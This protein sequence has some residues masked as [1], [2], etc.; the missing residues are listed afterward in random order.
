[1]VEKAEHAIETSN[2][3]V[4]PV[5]AGNIVNNQVCYRTLKIIIS[6]VTFK[7][8]ICKLFFFSYQQIEE[9]DGEN[10]PIE[11]APL[12]TILYLHV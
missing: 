7:S 4:M 8:E 3:E 1:M 11:Y 5:P 12:T 10:E 2:S 9:Y 6:Y